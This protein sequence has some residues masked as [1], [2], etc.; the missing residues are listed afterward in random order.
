MVR[1]SDRIHWLLLLRFPPAGHAVLQR[2]LVAIGDAAM[3][4]LKLLVSSRAE[5][6]GEGDVLGLPPRPAS[7]LVLRTHTAIM[8]R[9]FLTSKEQDHLVEQLRDKGKKGNFEDNFK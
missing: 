6:V 8:R 7:N 3:A 5:E 9:P 2:D 4:L 1:I